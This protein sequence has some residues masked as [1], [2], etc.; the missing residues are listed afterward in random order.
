MPYGY[1]FE[2]IGSGPTRS[3]GHGGIAA[4]VNFELRYFPH[5][6][7]TLIMFSNQDNGAYDDLKRNV[8]KL[9][10]GER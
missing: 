5:S 10:T 4:G 1:G 3:F 8:T 9:I 2:P 6:N 7:I